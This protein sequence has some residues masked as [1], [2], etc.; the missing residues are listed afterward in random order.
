MIPAN[1]LGETP[2]LFQQP[3]P[4]SRL[5]GPTDRQ[6]DRQTDQARQEAGQGPLPVQWTAFPQ[7]GSAPVCPGK[8]C[9]SQCHVRGRSSWVKLA[10]IYVQEKKTLSTKLIRMWPEKEYFF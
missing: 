8:G 10:I 7:P 5:R 1:H 4:P 3:A 6:R 9:V 2:G